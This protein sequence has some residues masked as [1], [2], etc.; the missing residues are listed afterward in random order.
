MRRGFPCAEGLDE[1]RLLGWLDQAAQRVQVETRRHWY[2]LMQPRAHITASLFLLLFPAAS[3]EEDLGVRYNPGGF[4]DTKFQDPKCFDPD[5]RDSRDLLIHGMIDGP[6]GTCASMP[7]MYVAVGRRL[8]YPLKL[9]Q[10]RG[11]LFANGTSRRQMFRLP[12][13]VQHRGFW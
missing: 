3:S 12:G 13:D 1:S 7:V 5:F 9:V 2:R 11:H 10:S 6:G 4:V 8:G